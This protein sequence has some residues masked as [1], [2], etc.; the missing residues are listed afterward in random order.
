MSARVC[1][2]LFAGRAGYVAKSGWGPWSASVASV[3]ILILSAIL[4]LALNEAVIELFGFARP[5]DHD[6]PGVGS[7]ALNPHDLLLL[8]YMQV[9]TVVISLVLARQFKCDPTD[10]LALRVPVQGWGVVAPA[11][12]MMIVAVGLYS[13]VGYSLWPDAVRSDLKPVVGV[14]RS[15]YG[16]LMVLLAIIGAPLSEEVLFRGFL[17]SALARSRLGFVGGALI[18]NIAWTA[19]HAHY[20]LVG[21]GAVF[22][23]GIMQCWLLWRTGSLWVPIICHGLYNALVVGLLYLLPMDWVT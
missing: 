12:G 17:L 23:V 10:A 20:S 11:F 4:G 22:L 2:D 18:A 5:G 21:L 15:D 3:G 9:F 8:L 16:P 7:S 14:L 13:V 1:K 19:L 6:A